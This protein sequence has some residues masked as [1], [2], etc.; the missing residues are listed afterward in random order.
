M[1]G[2]GREGERGIEV[3]SM[4]L[5]Q[6]DEKLEVLFTNMSLIGKGAVSW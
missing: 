3:M 5:C 2:R 4:F 1:R 6:V